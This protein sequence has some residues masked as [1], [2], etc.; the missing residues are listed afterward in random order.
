MR[1]IIII[2]FIVLV[3]YVALMW[4][5]KRK[6]VAG[7]FVFCQLVDELESAFRKAEKIRKDESTCNVEQPILEEHIKLTYN[8]KR[9]DLYYVQFEL[10]CIEIS[11]IYDSIEQYERHFRSDD[12][13]NVRKAQERLER[14][15]QHIRY[16]EWQRGYRKV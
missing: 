11:D 8:P 9:M 1:Y 6:A 12:W 16:E 14:I 5:R 7:G 10:L 4:K 13:E 3:G 15:F 2:C